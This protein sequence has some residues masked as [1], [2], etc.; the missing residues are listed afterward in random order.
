MSAR[1]RGPTM[2]PSPESMRPTL[3]G[4]HGLVVAGH[5]LA[6]QAASE[7]LAVGGNAV[8][9]AVAAGLMLSVVHGDMCSL[10][11]IVPMLVADPATDTSW[12]VA[13][14]GTW[15][16]TAS[17][18]AFR[19]RHGDQQ[20]SGLAAT[21]VP[22]AVAAYCAVLE[23]FGRLDLATVAKPAW[24]T[25]QDGYVVDQVVVSGFE[26][27]GEAFARWP[28]T[29]EVFWPKGRAP[30]VGEVLRQPDL[31]A[32]FAQ[33]CAAG[34]TQQA[35][36]AF[37]EGPI[38]DIIV[39]FVSDG[40][41]FLTKEDMAGFEATIAEAPNRRYR[42][43]EVATT[44]TWSQGPMML[45]TLGIL[46]R[47][48]IAALGH[49]STEHLHLLA[50][51]T[52][53]AASDREAYYGSGPDVPIEWLLSDERAAELADMVQPDGVLHNLP[54]IRPMLSGTTHF[55]V[56][57]ADGLACTGAPSDT[58]SLGP[59]VPGLGFVASPRG[60][61][62]RLD[63]AH[64]A[65]LRPGARPRVTPG[66]AIARDDNGAL[67][68]LSC[69]G[70]DVIMQAQVQVFSNLVDFGLTPQQAVEAPRVCSLAF[71]LSFAPDIEVERQ[72]CVEERIAPATRD[73]LEALGHRVQDW[74]EWEFDA[75]SVSVVIHHP[76]RTLSA[77]AD[78]RRAA[79]AAG[80]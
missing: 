49:N 71:P 65:A 46:E 3:H 73:A 34:S 16:A 75:G 19:A 36:R 44:P 40:G 42:R 79:Y 31:A 60:V 14:V 13:G 15:S 56:V 26:L 78:P 61:Q 24:Q 7:T 5:P 38:A 48:D 29:T 64:P 23:R 25:A 51:A 41:G 12:S 9:A 18:E 32:V 33:L 4:T 2:F 35:H 54:T 55:T 74:P 47:S 1:E 10:G 53:L 11:G 62:S 17:I 66:A 20:P 52:K 28:S 22:A 70:A 43:L 30:R 50:E 6:A 63:P 68:A 45:Q 67:I 80:R 27:F 72:L 39:D 37:Y 21:V 58:V 59:V 76:N 69:P 57:D 8:D 77:G